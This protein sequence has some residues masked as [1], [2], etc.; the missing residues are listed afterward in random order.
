VPLNG[1]QNT[2]RIMGLLA[3][4]VAL[5]TPPWTL[6]SRRPSG[7]CNR[8]VGMQARMP[9]HAKKMRRAVF[10]RGHGTYACDGA[11]D[12]MPQA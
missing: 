11:A 4:L 7:Q 6:R 8:R 12:A 10:D 5:N 9:V 2:K 3:Q 1:A